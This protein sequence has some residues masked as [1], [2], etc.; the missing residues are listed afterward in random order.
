[1]SSLVDSKEF[2]DAAKLQK[3]ADHYFKRLMRIPEAQIAKTTPL[4]DKSNLFGIDGVD[5]VDGM[6]FS[7]G[8]GFPYF[9]P[10][11]KLLN[12]TRDSNGP[13]VTIPEFTRARIEEAEKKCKEGIRPC[14]IFNSSL[15]DEP[16]SEKK[17]TQGKVRVFQAI[18]FEGLFLIRK[19][20]LSI[21]CLLQ[22][23]NLLS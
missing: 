8:A 4:D 21:V 17:N 23:Y 5:F 15:K 12:Y 19:Y 7:K 6:N 18:S 20:F 10:K 16:I 1:M 3:C 22:H 2:F 13:Q 14:F 9:K 11:S